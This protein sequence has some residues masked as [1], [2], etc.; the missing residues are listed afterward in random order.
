MRLTGAEE[1]S[2]RVPVSADGPVDAVILAVKAQ[3]LPSAADTVARLL[4]PDTPIVAAQ[5]GGPWWMHGG[6]DGLDPVRALGLVVYMGASIVAPGVVSTRREAGLIIGEPDGSD[7]ERLRAVA[8]AL[9]DAGFAVRVTGDIRTEL[10]TKLMGNAAFN[11]LSILT[12][13]GLGTMASDPD[14]RA[15]AAAIMAETVAVARATGSN[16]TISVEDRLA[17]TARLG[18]HK[19]S[20]LQDLEAGKRLELDAI[21][22][23]IIELADAADVPVDT[24][25]AVYALANLQALSLGLR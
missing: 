7:T 11:L 16:P 19:T 8:A 18:D 23:A 2:I 9:S 10:W 21:G 3:D 15:L 4:G 24:L 14:V 22:G 25:R 17:I 12:R 6:V 20:T 1:L 13:A 5:N